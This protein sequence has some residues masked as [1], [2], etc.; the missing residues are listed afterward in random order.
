MRK[1]GEGEKV[2]H[3]RVIC[4]VPPPLEQ[5]ADE[6]ERGGEGEKVAHHIVICHV[7]FPPE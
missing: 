3:H 5:K 6:K 1:R 2:G 7:P 4:H